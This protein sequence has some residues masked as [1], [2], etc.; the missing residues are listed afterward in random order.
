MILEGERSSCCHHHWPWMEKEY[1]F[2]SRSASACSWWSSSN[3]GDYPME[4]CFWWQEAVWGGGWDCDVSTFHRV[5]I[6]RSN[7]GF[8]PRSPLL[9]CLQPHHLKPNSI[10]HI[11]FFCLFLW[12]LLRNSTPLWSFLIPFPCLT[13]TEYGIHVWSWRSWNP[14]EA[15]DGR[16]VH[17]V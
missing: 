11:S 14:I 5:R 12:D 10:L 9:L 3:Q 4:I 2:W 7:F 1:V 13:A 17:P 6:S 15:R 16:E 8:I